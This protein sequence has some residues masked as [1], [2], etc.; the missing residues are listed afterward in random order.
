MPAVIGD[1]HEQPIVLG[2]VLTC[3]FNE[4]IG[5]AVTVYYRLDIGMVLIPE[6]I[7][8]TVVVGVFKDAENDLI[9]AEDGLFD[10]VKGLA[11]LCALLETVIFQLK[12]LFFFKE[13]VEKCI[14]CGVKGYSFASSG[15]I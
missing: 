3:R 11:V 14:P 2:E 4:R 15:S 12:I 13:A 5:I 10:V 8:V 1:D 6:N 7:T 9:P